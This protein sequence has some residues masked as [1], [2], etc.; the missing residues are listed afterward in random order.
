M[1][2]Y[3]VTLIKKW[4]RPDNKRWILPG[5]VMTVLP[6]LKDSLERGGFISGAQQVTQVKTRIEDPDE[7]VEET[8]K[9]PAKNRKKLTNDK[10]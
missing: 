1:A 5:A 3:Q 2:V 8:P 4:Q 6:S 7:A 10:N 9:P